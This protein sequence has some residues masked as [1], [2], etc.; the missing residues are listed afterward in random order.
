VT[1]HADTAVPLLVCDSKG[2]VVHANSLLACKLGTT[3]RKIQVRMT[4]DR[5]RRLSCTATL[6]ASDAALGFAGRIS[7]P[8]LVL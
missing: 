7:P 3:Q 4:A 2:Q 5:V 6:A 8:K 1:L